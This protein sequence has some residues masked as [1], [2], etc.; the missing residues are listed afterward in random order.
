[1]IPF[2]TFCTCLFKTYTMEFSYV[3]PKQ[4]AISKFVS[5][6]VKYPKDKYEWNYLMLNIFNTESG[7]SIVSVEYFKACDL[8]IQQQSNDCTLFYTIVGNDTVF[9]QGSLSHFLFSP[10]TSHKPVVYLIDGSNITIENLPSCRFIYKTGYFER[11]FDDNFFLE[12]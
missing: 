8:Y 5:D 3:E 4:E 11:F 6:L 1:M 12:E 7:D 9:I 10:I 2:L